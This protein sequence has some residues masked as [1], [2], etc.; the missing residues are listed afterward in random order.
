MQTLFQPEPKS[1]V[2]ME[3]E[4]ELFKSLL[5][6]KTLFIF[7]VGLSLSGAVAPTDV[8]RTSI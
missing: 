2:E 5:T 4:N 1:Q 8:L 6:I 7:R 3:C